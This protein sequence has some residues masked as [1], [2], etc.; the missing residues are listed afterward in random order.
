MW[1]EVLTMNE[2]KCQGGNKSKMKDK[3]IKLV[4][5]LFILMLLAIDIICVLGIISLFAQGEFGFAVLSIY[6]AIFYG[7]LTIGT[8]K[9]L[10]DSFKQDGGQDE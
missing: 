5:L 3:F 4:P 9:K 8:L 2:L 7:W 6:G 1:Q 10:I